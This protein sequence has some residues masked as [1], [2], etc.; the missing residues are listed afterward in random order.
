MIQNNIIKCRRCQ[1]PLIVEE[2]NYHICFTKTIVTFRVD[3]ESNEYYAFDGKKWYRWFPEWLRK[4]SPK[5]QHPNG[6]PTEST[7]PNFASV[8]FT[9]LVLPTPLLPY[10]N[11]DPCFRR[12][13]KSVNKSNCFFRVM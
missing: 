10:N 4:S 12:F 13:K 7:E 1:S 5:N 2:L 8:V 6:T 9:K 3:S 11:N